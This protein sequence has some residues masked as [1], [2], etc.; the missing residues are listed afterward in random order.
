MSK[1]LTPLTKNQKN[2]IFIKDTKLLGECTASFVQSIRE[3][4]LT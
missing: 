3:R 2:S 4:K 1:E